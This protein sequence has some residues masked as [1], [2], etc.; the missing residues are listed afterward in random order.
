MVAIQS[1]GVNWVHQDPIT[2]S[3]RVTNS[4]GTVTS[5]IDLDPWGGETS[6]SSNQAFQ[7]HRYTTYERDANGSDDAM[8]RRYHAYWNH[9]DQPDPYEGSYDLTDPQSFN[10]YGYTQNDPV[11]STDP[12]GKEMELTLGCSAMYSSCYGSGGGGYE[13][14]PFDSGSIIFGGYNEVPAGIRGALAAY[15]Q[16][17]QNTRDQLRAQSAWNNGNFAR[18]IS[19]ILGNPN[20]GVSVD[21]LQLWGDLAIAFING[22]SQPIEIAQRLGIP[23]GA[24]GYAVRKGLEAVA[25]LVQ[26]ARKPDFYILTGAYEGAQ[27]SVA[28][29][30]GTTVTVSIGATAGNV[31]SL[32]AGWLLQANRPAE[33]DVVG[34]LTGP[35]FGGD[36]F[37]NPRTGWGAGFGAGLTRSPQAPGTRWAVMV[38]LGF[39]GGFSGG[40]G[41]TWSDLTSRF[42]P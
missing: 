22:Y 34:F 15:D 26:K 19:I 25:R 40:N 9:F 6:T 5:T 16:R 37:W 10:R 35:S 27:G 23:L 38:G 2:K 7:P 32:M 13:G 17:V 18:V 42:F 3:Q 8:M 4:S 39:G 12:T 30:R 31:A 1:S 29:T 11:N 41:W 36:I 21:G 24:P 28:V 33:A 14:T 20:V